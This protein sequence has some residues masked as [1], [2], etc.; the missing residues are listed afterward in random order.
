MDLLFVCS[1]RSE[2]LKVL[3]TSFVHARF[4]LV[5]SSSMREFTAMQSLSGTEHLTFLQ[6]ELRA[7][8]NK[9]ASLS[10]QLEE[11]TDFELIGLLESVTSSLQEGRPVQPPK[12]VSRLA[13][14]FLSS[15]S[16]PFGNGN[17]NGIQILGE[18][19]SGERTLLLAGL[20]WVTALVEEASRRRECC[21]ATGV[22]VE[23]VSHS[24]ARQ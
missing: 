18:L 24:S 6:Q 3:R 2:R 17:G 4:R 10:Q 7:V 9:E 22:M 15:N 11:L 13:V 19:D 14:D 5:F 12:E 21:T 8:L 16:D 23:G 1:D 20:I